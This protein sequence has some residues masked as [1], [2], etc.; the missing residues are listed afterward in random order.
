ML[1]RY[2][3]AMRQDGFTLVEVTIIL[4]VLVILSTIML[5]QLG[6]FNRLARFVKVKE[7]LGA[8]C[9]TMKKFLDEVMVRG[10]FEQPGGGVPEQ[11]T[12]AQSA[13]KRVHGGEAE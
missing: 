3:R 1:S 10:P 8:L 2:R 11:G 9:A 7:D 5:P 13:D 4:L 12:G 6:N